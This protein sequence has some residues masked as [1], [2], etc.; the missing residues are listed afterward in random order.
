MSIS[1]KTIYDHGQI[2]WLADAPTVEEARVIVT[3]F[4]SQAVAATQPSRKP[5]ARIAGKG[6]VLDDIV[7]PVAPQVDWHALK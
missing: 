5:T 2:R 7:A 4:P 1:Y 6:K 3:M